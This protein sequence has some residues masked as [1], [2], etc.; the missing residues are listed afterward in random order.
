MNRLLQRFLL[1]V[2]ATFI[3]WNAYAHQDEES[4]IRFIENKGQWEDFILYSAEVPGGQVFLET[5]QITFTFCDYSQLHDNWFYRKT[6]AE[7]TFPIDCH[8]FSLRFLGGNLTAQAIASDPESYYYNYF[9]GNQSSKWASKA[10]AFQSVRYQ[11]VYPGIDFILYGTHE[12]MKYDFIVHPGAN[13]DLIKMEFEGLDSMFLHAG[14]LHLNTSLNKV[15][16]E[17]PVSFQGDELVATDFQMDGHVVSFDLK[18]GYDTN[19]EL[20]IDPTLVFS[21]YTGSS[22]NNFGFTATY[23]DDGNLLAGGIAFGTGYPTTIGSYQVLFTGGFDMSI[24][25][26]DDTGNHLW[27]TYIGG[28]SSDQPHSMIADPNTGELFVYGRSSSNDYPTTTGAADETHNGDFDIVVSKLSATGANLIASTYVGG[29]GVDGLNETAAYLQQGIKYNYADDARGEIIL[30]DQGGVY[31]ASCT[32]SPDFPAI[33]A[34]QGNLNGTQDACVFKLNNTLTN[35][36]FSTYLGGSSQEAAYSLKV[37]LNNRVFVTGGTNSNNF[38]T[39]AG[40]IMPNPGGNI[41]GFISHISASGNGLISSTYIGN[42]TYNQCY[43][44]ELDADENVYVVGQKTGSWP[45]FPAGIWSTPNGGG[46]FLMKLNNALSTTIYSTEFGTT[47]AQVNISPTAFLVDVCGFIY[48]SGWGGGTNFGGSTLGLP[49]SANALQSTTDGSD[50][51]LLVLQPD[52][53]GIEY[54]T[55]IGGTQSEEHVDG[56]TSRFNKRS[57]VYQSVCAGCQGNSDWPTTPGAFSSSNNSPGCNLACFKLDLD[58]KAVVAAFDTDPDTIG[59]A[60]QFVNFI[61]NSEG[62]NSFFWDFGDNTTDNTTSTLVNPSHNY[63]L[64]GS[65]PV[66]LIAVDSTTCNVADTV[67]RILTVLA[68]PVATVT[69]DTS[70]CEGEN[71]ALFAGGG[72]NYTWSPAQFLNQTTGSAVTAVN[73]TSNITYTVIVDNGQGCADTTEVDVEVLAVPTA[74]ADGDTLICPGDTV[75]ISATGGSTYSWSPSGSLTNPNAGVTDAFPS[76]T[77][78]YLVTVVAPNGC[79]DEDTV[80]VE[81]SIIQANAGGD[82]D[83]CIG[84]SLELNGTGGGT[85]S[86]FPPANLSDPNI[87]NPLA[88]PSS[89]ITYYLTVTN[90]IGCTALDSIAITIRPL[91][92]VAAGSDVLICDNDSIQLNASGAVA[93]QW[94]PPTNLSNPNSGTPFASPDNPTTYTVVGTD[95]FGCRNTDSLFIDVIP[96]PTA[97]AFGGQRICQDSSIQLFATGGITYS[98]APA[99]SL[100]DP[101]LQDPIATPSNTTIYTVTVFALNGCD[102]TDTVHVPVTP[103]PV[104]DISGP[105]TICLGKGARLFASGADNYEWNTG[106]TND[107][108]TVDPPMSTIYSLVGFVDGCPSL[109]DSFLLTVDDILPYADFY[110]DPDSGW[111]PL[112]TTFYNQ[113]SDA[114][115]YFWDYGDGNGSMEFQPTH[116]Y[117]DSGRFVVELVAVDENGCA[118]TA[119][120]RVIVGADFSIYIPNAFT[121]NGDGTND[122]FSTPYFGVQEFE[123]QIYDRWG[124]LIY[125]SFDPDFQW[126]GFYKSRECQEGV[127]TYVITARGYVGEKIRRAGTVTLYR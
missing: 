55:F 82:A 80:R 125:E 119:R 126:S 71:I 16:D 33:S 32:R 50:L 69:P 122:F 90:A 79:T 46:Q 96:S 60:P 95:Q 109:P 7:G 1:F 110:A 38:P 48:V 106:S 94:S 9:Q 68:V 17:H 49:T 52:A 6:E 72:T 115:Q 101:N 105:D 124:M 114:I 56:G 13:P 8:S 87:S 93:Y 98:W 43:F 107:Y 100:N 84:D 18:E 116:T 123:I 118:D 58:A 26:F 53:A 104:I 59:C 31:V 22:A 47:N 4:P 30:D 37:D 51:Y 102:D 25:K 54:A 120:T 86:W 89:D 61:N 12:G 103:T 108:I 40:V 35:L 85:Y 62:G 92:I 10:Q 42:A 15:I 91:P 78:D 75:G 70:V 117:Q 11:D 127:Y 66:T 113:S 34:L 121:P 81:V 99:T 36:Q 19:R 63:P 2:A 3:S 73:P 24:T 45:V 77:T 88:D 20:R 97:D 23:D 57:E 65:Y 5:D 27:S 74:A 41:D 29:S 83:L 14:E 112:T 67:T 28:S 21:T 111:V 44:I 64:P 76:T 39:T